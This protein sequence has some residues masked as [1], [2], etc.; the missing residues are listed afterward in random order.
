M[1][2]FPAVL[3]FYIFFLSRHLATFETAPPTLQTPIWAGRP[4][5]A[6]YRSAFP[7]GLQEQPVGRVAALVVIQAAATELG[8]EVVGT[9]RDG[10]RRTG[11]TS[12]PREPLSRLLC[13]PD[14]V[15]GL[16]R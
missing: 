15:V 9:K 14:K 13:G 5:G 4:A 3:C 10:L 7:V 11:T 6:A 2:F 12:R 16:G 1:S 8:Q